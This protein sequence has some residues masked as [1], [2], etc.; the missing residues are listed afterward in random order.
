ME[1]IIGNDQSPLQVEQIIDDS[2]RKKLRIRRS[3]EDDLLKPPI[4]ETVKSRPSTIEH[5]RYLREA[6]VKNKHHEPFLLFAS[7]FF[8]FIDYSDFF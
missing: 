8:H 2:R 5:H 4:N 1:K 6:E 7:D 3:V